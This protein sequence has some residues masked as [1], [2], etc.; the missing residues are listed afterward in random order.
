MPAPPKR[1]ALAL[2]VVLAAWLGVPGPAPG[3]P[4]GDEG[5]AA[6][7]AAGPAEP[8]GGT[9]DAGADASRS[10]PYERLLDE[11]FLHLNILP[12][13]GGGFS[14][15]QDDDGAEV[16][17][18]EWPLLEGD[19]RIRSFAYTLRD[20]AAWDVLGRLPRLEVVT[21]HSSSLPGDP[22]ARPGAFAELEVLGIV[23]YIPHDEADRADDRPAPAPAADLKSIGDLPRLRTLFIDSEGLTDDVLGHVGEASGLLSLSLDGFFTDGGLR[24]VGELTGLKRLSLDGDFTDDG[25]RHLRGLT[26]LECLEL[27]SR[28]LHGPGLA[29]LA[30]LP[31]LRDLRLA[32]AAPDLSLA[33]LSKVPSLEVLDLSVRYLWDGPIGDETLATLPPL[34]GLESLSL[35]GTEIGDGG[36]GPLFRLTG[37]EELDLTETP[38]TDVGVGALAKA[39]T[40]QENLRVLLLGSRISD[41]T[42]PSAVTESGLARLSRLRR[43]AELDVGGVNLLT[44]DLQ[45]LAVPSLRHLSVGVNWVYTE[46]MREYESFVHR[47]PLLKSTDSIPIRANLFDRGDLL[48]YDFRTDRLT[49]AP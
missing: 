42:V 3:E 16:G 18:D 49:V 17:E 13:L 46:R 19:P 26:E 33:E 6:S 21:Q 39:P 31:N 12:A 32:R 9:G 10:D 24:E 35:S 14:L 30:A 44:A 27:K 48:M 41:W 23:G 1:F 22:F 28:N 29:D 43:L 20:A 40:L 45:V 8:A 36:L 25:L 2:P 15:I 5:Q 7:G 34:P 37:L 47:R 4:P 38:V 11:S